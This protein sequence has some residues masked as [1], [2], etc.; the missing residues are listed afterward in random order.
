MTE[1]KPG[2][3]DPRFIALVDVVRR[4]GA[5]EVQIRYDEEQQPIVW[6][7]VAGYRVHGGRPR[8]TGKVNHWKAAGAIDPLG[9]VY[10]LAE[11]AIDGG[12]C[13]H[14]QRPTGITDDWT[15]TMPLD[16]LVCW[17]VYDPEM[18]TFR[19]SCEGDSTQSAHESEGPQA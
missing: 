13:T 18:Q 17:Y 3:Q 15:V 16:D 7:A 19:R 11:E 12:H 8:S 2:P 10:R 6:V 4:T 5:A 14:C 9:A 1:A